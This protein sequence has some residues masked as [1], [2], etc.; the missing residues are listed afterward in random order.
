M[1]TTA[2]RILD[3][4]RRRFNEQ[5]YDSTTISQIAE[6]VGI[7]PGNLTYHFPTK[8][9]LVLTLREQLMERITSRTATLA[10]GDVADD[11]VERLVFMLDV[12]STYR[13]LLRDRMSFD[14]APSA[15]GP[16][17]EMTASLDELKQLI[18]R[19]R[20]EGLMRT[21]V[22]V[23]PDTLATTVF[24]VGRH[25]PDHL[26]EME[27]RVEMTDADLLRGAEHHLTVL[28]PYLNAA[29]RRS[30]SEALRRASGTAGII[31]PLGVTG[32]PPAPA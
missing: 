26:R 18:A 27:G 25:W 14:D 24:I 11:Y 23:D 9:D 8:H 32:A 15:P 20:A 13:C 29:G 31:L 10:P 30:F 6:D 16:T 2:E 28:M 7:R 12:N 3:A 19:I 4:A 21:D 22:G 5:G 1:T 17:P